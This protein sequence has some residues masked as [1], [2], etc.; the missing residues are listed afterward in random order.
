QDDP[1][2]DNARH[3]QTGQREYASERQRATLQ[4]IN[5]KAWNPLPEGLSAIGRT[6]EMQLLGAQR[7]TRGVIRRIGVERDAAIAITALARWTLPGGRLRRMVTAEGL[8]HKGGFLMRA[9]TRRTLL[10]GQKKRARK[11]PSFST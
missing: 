3:E 8:V 6:E 11:G 9:Q 5:E 10:S 4:G 1:E 2:N 7:T